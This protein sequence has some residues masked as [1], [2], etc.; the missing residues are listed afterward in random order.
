MAGKRFRVTAP[1]VDLPVS[2]P[3]LLG[4]SYMEGEAEREGWIEMERGERKR[5]GETE[6]GERKREGR[7]H[8]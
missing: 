1:V 5:A 6:N 8:K 2:S 7:T 4:G 3:L